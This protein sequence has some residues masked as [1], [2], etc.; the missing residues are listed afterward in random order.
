[1]E[2]SASPS[3]FW[4]SQGMGF[5][6]VSLDLSS[7]SRRQETNVEKTLFWVSPLPLALYVAL[8]NRVHCTEPQILSA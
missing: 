7:L 8:G 2:G 6:K 1:M 3:A 5:V 4:S